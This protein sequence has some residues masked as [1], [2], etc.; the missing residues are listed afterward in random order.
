MQNDAGMFSIAD[1]V[2]VLTE[3]VD[4]T[5]LCSFIFDVCK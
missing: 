1:G 4:V 2:C 5:E 3:V